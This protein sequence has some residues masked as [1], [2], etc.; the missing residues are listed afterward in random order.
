[1]ETPLSSKC[2]NGQQLT[3]EQR[4]IF[5][6]IMPAYNAETTIA[7]AT[8][9]VL[10]QTEPRFEL[11]IINDG[12]SD[13]TQAII[14][15][16]TKQ[17]GRIVAITL[18][19]NLGVATARNHGITRASGRYIAFL[20]AD[21]YWLNDKLAEQ[22]KLFKQGA[23]V[24]FSPYYREKGQT[25]QLVSVPLTINYHT[26]LR[27]NCIG[28]LTGSY[29]AIT[30][31][32][33]YQKSVGHEDYLMWLDATKRGQVAYSTQRPTAVYTVSNASISANK[34]RSAL[35][36]WKILR[37]QLNL[38]WHKAAFYFNAYLFNAIRKRY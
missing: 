8:T 18:C 36:T 27:G 7:R 22:L 19:H 5:S 32:K 4:P 12:S 35:W 15:K 28:N 34:W 1:M 21:D 23:Q 6:V 9:S 20:D 31:G 3:A 37:T 14:D 30:I 26:L 29:D 33:I 11:I 2:E 13:N 10:S 16:L 38:P 24:V 25:R 17:D